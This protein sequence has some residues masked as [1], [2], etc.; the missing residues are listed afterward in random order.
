[1]TKLTKLF[2]SNEEFENVGLYIVLLFSMGYTGE[3]VE[4]FV[5]EFIADE[6]TKAVVEAFVP[7]LKLALEE[8]VDD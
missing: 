6:K 2:T 8:I 4:E 1:M 3:D 7:V 5:E